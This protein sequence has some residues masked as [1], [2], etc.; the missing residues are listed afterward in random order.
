MRRPLVTVILAIAT[1]IAG[2]AV[3]TSCGSHATQAVSSSGPS[4][5][6]APTT[7][8]GGVVS[9]SSP[10]TQSSPPNQSSPSTPSTPP[11]I[12]P[13][14]TASE[15]PNRADL[16]GGRAV[17]PDS[18][19]VD[20]QDPRVVHVRFWGG[21]PSCSAASVTVRESAASV[22]VT[23]RTGRVPSGAN[24]MCPDLAEFE[25]IS[26]RLAAPLGSRAL[27]AAS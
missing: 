24:M 3:L 26:V 10:P 16:V 6:I 4:T 11:G 27:S 22:V 8:P 14:R 15:V 12:V 2:V 9:T 18:L 25:Q 23:L 19:I 5:T 13:N 17:T 21:I 7:L 1:A 20:H